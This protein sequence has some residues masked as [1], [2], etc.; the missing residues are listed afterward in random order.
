MGGQRARSTSEGRHL[1]RRPRLCRAS[2]KVTQ[3]NTAES[4]GGQRG[5]NPYWKLLLDRSSLWASTIGPRRTQPVSTTR[6]FQPYSPA[7]SRPRLLETSL[8]FET[9]HWT[10][11]SR[12]KGLL[13]STLAPNGVPLHQEICRTTWKRLGRSA[14]L[15]PLRE[16]SCGQR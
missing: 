16:Y 11:L 1:L 10:G 8:G 12:Y 2:T 15:R 5:C 13:N 9:S 14:G 7:K 3:L 6:I 4:G